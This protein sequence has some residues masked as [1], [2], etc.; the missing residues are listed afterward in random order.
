MPI[1]TAA[2]GYKTIANKVAPSIGSSSDVYT[3]IDDAHSQVVGILRFS[4]SIA[5][6]LGLTD[7][8]K[9]SD[10]EFTQASLKIKIRNPVQS[11]FTFSVSG[12]GLAASNT[13]MAVITNSSYYQSGFGFSGTNAAEQYVTFDLLN[14]FKNVPDT[15][16]SNVTTGTWYLYLWGGSYSSGT[17]RF[18]RSSNYA[19]Q[20][21][22]EGRKKG[23]MGYYNGTDW[24]TCQIKYYVDSTTGWQD[25]EA[26]YYDG[27]DWI[28][29]GGP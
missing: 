18:Y 26:K 7:A 9:W 20:L 1:L 8:T 14:L 19:P 11:S 10:I 16:S 13:S 3:S 29:V 28:P 17:K 22:L 23:G 2:T 27:N 6:A 24:E 5:S 4:T 25:C 21:T 15:N 12:T